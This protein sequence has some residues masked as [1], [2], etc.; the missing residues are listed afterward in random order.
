MDRAVPPHR[1]V[2]E[3][4]IRAGIAASMLMHSAT[5]IRLL[6]S[7]AGGSIQPKKEPGRLTL[8]SVLVVSPHLSEGSNRA[9]DMCSGGVASAEM[10][11]ALQH[12]PCEWRGHSPVRPAPSDS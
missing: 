7:S 11:S 1:Q 12:E 10:C 3:V 6:C 4:A 8:Q 9:S 5:I 2:T